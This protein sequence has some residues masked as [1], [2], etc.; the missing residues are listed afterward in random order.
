M[1]QD[2]C[3]ALLADVEKAGAARDRQLCVSAAERIAVLEAALK[4]I[5]TG[6]KGGRQL[7]EWEL[8]E[9][10]TMALDSTP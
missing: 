10:A 3:K 1:S 6:M 4:I 5:A 7:E 9:A 2:L 8:R